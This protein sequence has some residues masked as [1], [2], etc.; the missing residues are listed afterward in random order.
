MAIE[1]TKTEQTELIDCLLDMGL[2]LLK[3]GAEIS[4][5]E[6]TV[7]R[8]A[9]AYGCIRADVFVITSIISL[10]IEFPDKEVLTDTRRIFSSS[11]TDFTR[12]E[13]L[14]RNLSQRSFW[15]AS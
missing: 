12:L 7:S 8:M 11:E 1:L 5:V 13:H 6:D 2:L 10:S 9:K 4:R 14:K 3:C 15:A